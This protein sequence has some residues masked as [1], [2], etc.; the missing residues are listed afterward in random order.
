[1]NG[2]LFSIITVLAWGAWLAPSQNVPLKSQH[3]RTFYVTLAV[4]VLSVIVAAYFGFDGLTFAESWAPFI[5]GLIWAVGGYCAFSAVS[6][7]GMAKAFGIWAPLNIISSIIWGI[8]LFGEFIN[9]PFNN[10]L[11][12]IIY[13]VMIVIG[14]LFIINSGRSDK[15]SQ[16]SRK[17]FINGVILSVFAGILLGSYFIPIRMAETSISMWVATFPLALGMFL[18]SI[19]LTLVTRTS[20][21]LDKKIYYFQVLST[22]ILWAI[23]NYGALR[24][25]EL[26]GTGK[27]Y[28]IAQLCVVVNALIGILIFKNPNP[29]SKAALLTFIGIAIATAGG[30]LL[31]NIQ[32]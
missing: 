22:G 25:M 6:K 21:K 23:G 5:G 26:I 1:M 13:L 27:G 8:I 32:F 18:G 2:I 7:I 19:M 10:I 16:S 12:G 15:N 31:G 11:K 9:T 3:T 24:M 29:R 20:I 28:T 14:L 17:D 4:L 30:I